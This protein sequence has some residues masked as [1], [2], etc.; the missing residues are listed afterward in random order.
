MDGGET[1]L[2][3]SR[4][5]WSTSSQLVLVIVQLEVGEAGVGDNKRSW[6][7]KELQDRIHRCSSR[8]TGPDS[9]GE[10]SGG[11]MEIRHQRNH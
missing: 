11:W 2:E 9:L 4:V 6:W 3:K 1:H 7:E 8:K 5:R 10:D